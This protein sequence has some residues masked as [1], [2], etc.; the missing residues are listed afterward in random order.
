MTRTRSVAV[1]LAFAA[2]LALPTAALAAYN[3]ND[4]DAFLREQAKCDAAIETSDEISIDVY[5]SAAAEALSLLASEVVQ[6][7]EKWAIFR[8]LE[9]SDLICAAASEENHNSRQASMHLVTATKIID[10]LV[11]LFPT[12]ERK[13]LQNTAH[14][15]IAHFGVAS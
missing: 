6:K 3:A 14:A 13:Q 12:A 1:A 9:A 10:E 7:N 8:T 11:V 15:L 5:C 4:G 2:A